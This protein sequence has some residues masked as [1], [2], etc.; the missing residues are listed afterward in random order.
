MFIL[1]KY[2]F[3]VVVAFI[4][5]QYAGYVKFDNIC[6]F[7]FSYWKK[8]IFQFKGMAAVEDCSNNIGKY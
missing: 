7:L 4:K 5:I 2:L 3:F 1:S 6:Q 8:N